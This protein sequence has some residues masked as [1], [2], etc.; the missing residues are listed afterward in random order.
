MDSSIFDLQLFN[1]LCISWDESITNGSIMKTLWESEKNC[2]GRC[3][4]YVAACRWEHRWVNAQKLFALELL[5]IYLREGPK[6]F[7]GLWLATQSIR[8]YV[9]DGSTKEGE[10]QLKTIFEL[11]QY[12]FIFHQDSNVLPIIDRVFNNVL[13]ILAK[14]KDSKA[15]AWRSHSLH[16]GRSEHWI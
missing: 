1:I 5:G 6:Y 12:K 3:H 4:T 9:P 13:T 10:K 11:A 2:V 7:T 15:T 8:D 16:F 14:R